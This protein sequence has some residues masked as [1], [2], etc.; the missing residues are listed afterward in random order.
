MERLARAKFST[1]KLLARGKANVGRAVAGQNELGK[2][3][4]RAS[5]EQA[6]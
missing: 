1:A 4:M 5:A 2:I 3:L 6:G